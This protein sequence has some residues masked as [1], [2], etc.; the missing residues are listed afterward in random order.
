[1]VQNRIPDITTLYESHDIELTRQLLK[2]YDI[3]YVVVTTFEREKYPNLYEEKFLQIGGKIVN[4][5]DGFGALYS[6]KQ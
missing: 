6:V 5:K 4:T 2:K 3:D 1:M